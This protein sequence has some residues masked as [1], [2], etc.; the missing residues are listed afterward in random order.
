MN[1]E[2]ILSYYKTIDIICQL[3]FYS[4]IMTVIFNDN[5]ESFFL[6]GLPNRCKFC[7]VNSVMSLYSV[8]NH[9]VFE[10]NRKN[11]SV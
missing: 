8:G 10:K 6:L 5:L 3:F 11:M 2:H 4:L 7:S 1:I 9:G